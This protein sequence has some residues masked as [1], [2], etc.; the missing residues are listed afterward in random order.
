MV[1][2]KY[3]SENICREE[4]IFGSNFDQNFATMIKITAQCNFLTPI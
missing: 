1:S 3:L 4:V 2:S